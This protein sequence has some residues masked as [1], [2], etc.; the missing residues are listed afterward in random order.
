MKCRGQVGSMELLRKML[1]N[2]RRETCLEERRPGRRRCRRS[3]NKCGSITSRE[4]RK[5]LSYFLPDE[6]GFCSMWLGNEFNPYRTNV[7]NRVST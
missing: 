4:F 3:T 5:E 1:Q 6:E 2:F 7:E